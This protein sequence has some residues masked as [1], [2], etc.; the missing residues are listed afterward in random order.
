MTRSAVFGIVF[1]GILSTFCGL[2][3]KVEAIWVL[4][5]EQCITVRDFQIVN[6]QL[7]YPAIRN[8]IAA[9]EITSKNGLYAHLEDGSSFVVSSSEFDIYKEWDAGDPVCLELRRIYLKVKGIWDREQLML[10]NYR[11]KQSVKVDIANHATTVPLTVAAVEPYELSSEIVL[12][13]LFY[14]NSGVEKLKNPW[15]VRYLV[16][17]K[18][19]VDAAI[20]KISQGVDDKWKPILMRYLTQDERPIFKKKVE[21]GKVLILSDGSRWVT[22]NNCDSFDVGTPIIVIGQEEPDDIYDFLL[23]SQSGYHFNSVHAQR[24]TTTAD[25]QP[26]EWIKEVPTFPYADLSKWAETEAARIFI[27]RSWKE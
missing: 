17:W 1:L 9:T 5:P 19:G 21:P 12:F 23:I 7:M 13:P 18:G 4:P 16:E 2:P 11:L 25:Y 10:Y 22:R 20:E 6:Y 3:S 14:Q 15:Q 27:S 24:E 8:T 26:A